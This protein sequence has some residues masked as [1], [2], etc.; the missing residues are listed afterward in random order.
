MLILDSEP[1][2]LF[3]NSLR[4]TESRK[5]YPVYLKKYMKLQGLTDLLAEKDPRLIEHQIIDFIIKMK[6]KGRGFSAIHNYV[7]VIMSFYRINDVVLNQN[8]ISKFMPENKRIMKDRAYTAPEISNLLQ[9]AD[10]RMRVIILLLASSGMRVGALPDLKLRNLEK[11]GSPDMYKMTVYENFKEEYTTFCTFECLQAIDFYLEFRKRYGEKLN[12]E[13]LLIREQFDV[14]DQFA[15]EK[16]V[17]TRVKS[18]TYKLMDLATRAGI[19]KREHILEGQTS[20]DGASLRKEVA[21]AHGFRKF[22]T[23]QCVNSKVDP[24]VREMLLGHKIGLVSAYY[25]PTDDEMLQ[26][27]IKA[28]DNLTINEENRLK[29]KVEK[30]QVEKSR[31]DRIEKQVME[32]ERIAAL[33]RAI[34]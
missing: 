15:V 4:S 33:S 22:F 1:Y 11:V 8:K 13:S 34:T 3:L 32:L 29:R 27:Y 23:T 2:I 16:P 28:T 26:E 24:Q 12:P 7:A 30:L 20:A 10:E 9:I 6:E 21:I 31:I 5:S 19:R 14:R 17:K 18:L 25:R